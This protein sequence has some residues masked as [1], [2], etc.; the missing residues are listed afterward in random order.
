MSTPTG[1]AHGRRFSH[2]LHRLCS[3]LIGTFL[4]LDS[5]ETLTQLDQM[6][7]WP[8]RLAI[9]HLDRGGFVSRMAHSGPRSVAI[10][11][12]CRISVKVGCSGLKT[13]SC[14]RTSIS[15]TLDVVCGGP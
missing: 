7:R 11:T 1:V 8:T 14:T 5:I 10:V 9:T 2:S 12:R 3:V 4:G 13:M 6:V 15:P